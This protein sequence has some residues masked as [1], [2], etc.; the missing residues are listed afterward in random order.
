MFVRFLPIPKC[1]RPMFLL[2]KPNF[3][4]QH[5]ENH[6]CMYCFFFSSFKQLIGINNNFT[7]CRT[8]NRFQAIEIWA[9]VWIKTQSENDWIDYVKIEIYCQIAVS[10]HFCLRSYI[11]T[12]KFTLA[13]IIALRMRAMWIMNQWIYILVVLFVFLFKFVQDLSR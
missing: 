2:N 5:V 11:C 1:I 4:L 10:W 6:Y 13:Q 12:I 3:M 7:H 9:H 8:M